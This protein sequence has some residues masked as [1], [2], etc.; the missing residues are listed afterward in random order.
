M[1]HERRILLSFDP[2][3]LTEVELPH[4]A[5]RHLVHVLRLQTGAQITIVDT[6]RALEHQAI[7][8]KREGITVAKIIITTQVE[9]KHSAVSSIALALCKGKVNDFVC[10]KA[11]EL[12][13][14]HMIMWAARRSIMKVESRDKEHKLSRWRK[15]VE[16]AAKQSGRSD[17]PDVH[18]VSSV[19]ELIDLYASI[20][21]SPERRLCCSLSPQ[22]L[23]FRKLQP[24]QTLS[25]LVIGPEGDLAPEEEEVLFAQGFEAL[26]LGAL[27]LRSDT[28]AITSI[29][30][31]LGAFDEA[32]RGTP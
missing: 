30:M 11:T 31:A 23:P 14:R 3:G 18:L 21:P 17:L 1:S 5:V 24:L 12:G 7:L 9:A 16:S 10:E 25:H 27:R 28:A 2:S 4:E 19:E 29:A 22:A 20:A 13:V 6:E 32:S 8:E 15:I 26:S